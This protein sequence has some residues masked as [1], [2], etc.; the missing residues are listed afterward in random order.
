[1]SMVGGFLNG[2]M[3]AISI[4]FTLVLANGIVGLISKD[5]NTLT[6]WTDKTFRMIPRSV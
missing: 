4:G 6:E 5:G 1:M 2:G 3:T